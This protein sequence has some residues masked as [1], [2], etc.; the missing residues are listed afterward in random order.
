M[1]NLVRS[2]LSIGFVHMPSPN[3]VMLLDVSS[4]EEERVPF[5]EQACAILVAGD[6]ATSFP[7]ASAVEGG[8]L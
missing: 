8:T 1:P 2:S 7:L 4:S 3:G 6:P 5:L